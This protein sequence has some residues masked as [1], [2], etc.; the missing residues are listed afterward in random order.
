MNEPES[1]A[2]SNV[3]KNASQMNALPRLLKNTMTKLFDVGRIK[4]RCGSLITDHSRVNQDS[5][6][7]IGLGTM[8]TSIREPHRCQHIGAMR[9]N[10]APYVR[11]QRAS[12][13]SFLSVS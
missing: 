11:H 3:V 4:S 9:Y 5:Q 1:A 7:S 6:L 12:K 8:G 13:R 10:F 2:I